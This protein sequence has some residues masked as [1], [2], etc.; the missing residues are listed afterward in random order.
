VSATRGILD[1]VRFERVD[2]GTVP[3][4][5]PGGGSTSIEQAAAA[6]GVPV[7][8]IERIVRSSMGAARTEWRWNGTEYVRSVAGAS[9]KPS[10]RD[11]IE[12]AEAAEILGVPLAEIMPIA[13]RMQTLPGAGTIAR[14][15]LEFVGEVILERR[16]R[17]RAAR[18][19]HIRAGFMRDGAAATLLGIR[20][21]R[22]DSLVRAG[23][24]RR[25]NYAGFLMLT[26]DSVAALHRRNHATS[27]Q[28]T[29]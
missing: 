9:R 24:L 6:L 17:A 4:K 22:I 10:G 20:E 21:D 7:A 8:E 1:G 2:A 12:F 5:L 19:A 16:A 14:H 18:C 28:A 27:A 25:A 23:W 26:I 3:Q 11:R 13:K 29:R 15:S